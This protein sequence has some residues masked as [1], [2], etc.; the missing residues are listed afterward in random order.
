ML[1][2]EVLRAA[3][4]RVGPERRLRSFLMDFVSPAEVGELRVDVHVHREGRAYTHAEARL[5]QGDALRAVALLAFGADR[6]TAVRVVS[7][8]RPNRRA[9]ST[10]AL[11]AW[12]LMPTPPSWLVFRD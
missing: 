11:L 10:C 8:S 2:K 12:R 3:R 1:K 9:V 5:V 6:S 4:G 7:S